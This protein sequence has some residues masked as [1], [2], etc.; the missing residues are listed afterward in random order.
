MEKEKKRKKKTTTTTTTHGEKYA[1][2]AKILK[3][4][5]KEFIWIKVY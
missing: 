3:L 5:A 4:V 2:M 1:S